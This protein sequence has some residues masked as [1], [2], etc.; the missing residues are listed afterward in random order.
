MSDLIEQAIETSAG[1]EHLAALVKALRAHSD[2]IREL[3]VISLDIFGSRVRGDERRD[4]DLDVLITYDPA[5]PFTLYDLIRVKRLLERLTGLTVHVS[6][7]DG[8]RPHRL[9]RV[10][11]DAVS[12][13]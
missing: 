9:H 3:G 8:F 6:T 11:R 1:G 2:E 7:R 13:L 4:S 12:V 5:R 10:L